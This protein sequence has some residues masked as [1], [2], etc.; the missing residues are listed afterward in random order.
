MKQRQSHKRRGDQPCESLGTDDGIDARDL[1]R[2]RSRKKSHHKAHQ[3]CRQVMET[4]NYILAGDLGDAR[5][6][7]IMVD[8]VTPAPDASRL[9]VS[10]RVMALKPDGDLNDVQ[11]ALQGASGLIRCEVASVVQRKKAPELVFQVIPEEGVP[12]E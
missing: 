4:I 7:Q 2:N 3:L 11:A 10:V 9:L 8:S 6:H 12:H 1:F 5:L